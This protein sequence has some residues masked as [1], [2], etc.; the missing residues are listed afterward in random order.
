M[1]TDELE[2]G[3]KYNWKSQP[4]RLVYIGR[5]WTGRWHRF[6]KI[7]NPNLIWCEVLQED[8]RMMEDTK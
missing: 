7:E 5:D 1:K 6:A 3:G 2:I 8:L 4:E